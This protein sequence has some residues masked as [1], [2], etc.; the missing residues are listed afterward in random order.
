MNRIQILQE[1]GITSWVPKQNLG[2]SSPHESVALPLSRPVVTSPDGIP[3]MHQSDL[4]SWVVVATPQ[5][6]KTPLFTKL[7]TVIRKFGVAIC[8]LEFKTADAWQSGLVNGNLLIAF[9]DAPG[10]FFSGEPSMAQELREIIF[11]TQNSI[12]DDIP[13]LVSHSME[14]LARHPIKKREVWQD[15]IMARAIFLEAN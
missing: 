1:M 4:P 2:A 5:D 10:K 11:E 3:S 8:V 14:A 9:G 13:V 7:M 15:L 12:G 6:I